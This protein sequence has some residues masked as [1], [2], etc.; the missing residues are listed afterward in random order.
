VVRGEGLA[1]VVGVYRALL[2]GAV[3]PDEGHV[4][5]I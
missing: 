1:A 5:S 2:D 4:L 3:A